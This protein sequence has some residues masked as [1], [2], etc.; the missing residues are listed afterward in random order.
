MLD[1]S[2]G[3]DRHAWRPGG[4]GIASVADLRTP[5]FA[6]VFAVLADCAYKPGSFAYSDKAFT[7]Q[8]VSVGC[9]DVSVE[10]RIDIPIGAVLDYTFANRCD[11]ALAI[12]LHAVP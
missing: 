8:R 4:R 10:R 7:G 12:D 9:L 6:V 3:R 11:H 5:A 1:P 2:T